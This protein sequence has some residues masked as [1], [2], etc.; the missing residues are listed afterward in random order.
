MKVSVHQAV[1]MAEPA[2]PID[3]MR[4]ESEK[5]LA[6]TVVLHDILPSIA[7]AGTLETIP[8]N[9][10]RC[11]RAT[12]RESAIKMCIYVEDQ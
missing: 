10:M 2:L 8:G 6:I 1:G 7:P 12:R 5:L 9:S 11:G 3:H 4:E